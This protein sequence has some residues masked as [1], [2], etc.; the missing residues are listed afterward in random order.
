MSIMQSTDRKSILIVVKLLYRKI[1]GLI[2]SGDGQQQAGPQIH[3]DHP[4]LMKAAPIFGVD[5]IKVG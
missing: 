4:Q 5:L 1:F 2:D 3:N